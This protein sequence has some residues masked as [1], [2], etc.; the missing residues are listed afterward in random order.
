[1]SQLHCFRKEKRKETT[2]LILKLSKLNLFNYVDRTAT[3]SKP[4]QLA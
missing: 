3:V 1:M 2:L 4:P